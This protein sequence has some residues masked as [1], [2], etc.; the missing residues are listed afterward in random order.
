MDKK[1][2][3]Q[4]IKKIMIAAIIAAIIMAAGI[5]EGS[6]LTT[7]NLIDKFYDEEL[8]ASS[9][10]MASELNNTYDGDWSLKGNDIYKGPD[11]IMEEYDKAMNAL[12]EKTSIEYALI[13]NDSIMITTI[14]NSDNSSQATGEKIPN[15]FVESVLKEN[16]EVSV[17]KLEIAGKSY[18][19]YLVP[20]SNG[21]KVVGMVFAGKPKKVTN[22]AIYSIANVIMAIAVAFVLAF[23]VVA[24]IFA[25]KITRRFRIM[26]DQVD[27]MTKGQLGI[28]F[29]KSNLDRKDEIGLISTGMKNLDQKLIDVI[30]KTKE[31]S[32]VLNESGKK[33]LDS[34]ESAINASNQVTSAVDDISN[35]A[36][37]QAES[38]Q[39]AAENTDAIDRDIELITGAVDELSTFAKSM[40]KSCDEAVEAM[41]M[42]ISKSEVVASSVNDIGKTIKSTN[43][44]AK[45]IATFSSAIQDIA[46]QTNLL[47][48]NA[49]I[50]AA[51]AGEAG[52]GFAVV[53]DEIRVLADQSANSADQ[54]DVIVR[55][56][57]EDAESSVDVMRKLDDNCR[58]QGSVLG[59]TRKDMS[60]MVSSVSSVS[61]SVAQIEQ[62]TDDL[63]K[64]KNNL[65]SIIEDLSA[66]SEENAASAQQTNASITELN[67]TFRALGESASSLQK[68]A[69]ELQ[70]NIDYFNI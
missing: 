11:N 69:H 47:S 9:I 27:S 34:A 3:K 57:V 38:V 58:E 21:N 10:Q 15:E 66:I 64:V 28:E 16:K 17:N 8:R 31:S 1:H 65:V 13:Y 22:S 39:T 56:L 62:R 59:T 54:I 30:G 37:A 50:E 7:R 70:D 43:E 35:G 20:I 40:R 12:H 19:G 29:E 32:L 4:L 36:T 55:K 23:I 68:L 67:E 60:S 6:I 48:L 26:A 25:K 2:N 49:S 33:L 18:F 52:K 51:R 53:A 45:Q 24:F 61:D 46:T 14:T 44:S 5:M 63:N 41:E 42:L